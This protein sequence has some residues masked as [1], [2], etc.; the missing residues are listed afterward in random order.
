MLLTILIIII[1]GLFAGAIINVL[2]DDLPHYRRPTTP[3]YADGA[4]RPLIAWLGILAFV[5][6]KRAS[7]EGAAL[8]WR[9][10]VAEV[11]TVAGMLIALL[12]KNARTDVSDTQLIFWLIDIIIM[13]L[14]TVVDI[15]HKLILFSVMIPAYVVAVLDAIITPAQ[16][17]PNLTAALIAGA[18]GFGVYYILYLGG[19]LY[20]YVA[21]Q[22]GRNIN[23]VAFGFGDVMLATFSG[24]ILGPGAL[25]FAMF[26]TVFAG[27]AGAVIYLISRRLSADG[28]SPFTALPYGP[29]IVLGTFL[30]LFFGS[31][32][33][34]LLIGY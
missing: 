7:P 23:T 4:R 26:I 17:E 1:I 25:I 12:V 19:I 27:A 24:L 8:S 15:E 34:Y 21:N 29:Y 14:V 2:A 22:Q 33:R 32:M 20:V 30:M 9:Y 28:Y 5:T 31:Q 3:R 6:G 11:A 13:V 18:V 16:R 10:P